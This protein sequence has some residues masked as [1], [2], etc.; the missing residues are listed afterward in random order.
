MARISEIHYSNDHASNTGVGEFFEVALSPGEDPADFVVS[1]YNQNGN[2]FV[3]LPLT[4]PGITSTVNP[5]TGETIYVINGATYGFV[6]TD[7]NGGNSNNEAV[8]LTDVSGTSNVVIDF[9]DVGGG[10]TAITANNGAA[11]GVT[12]TN[13]AGDFG[14][15]IQFNQPN[16]DT[17]IFAETSPGIACFVAGTPI[18]TSKGAI[19]IEDLSVG[20]LVLTM[21]NGFKPIRWI[22]SQTVSGMGRFAPYKITAGQFRACADTYLSPAHRV[23]LKNWRAELFFGASEVLVPVNSL[24]NHM[25]ITRA[26]RAEVIYVHMMFD[27]HE[28]VF[29]NGVASESFLPGDSGLDAMG[30]ETQEEIFA[31]FPELADDLGLYGAPARPILRGYE[32]RILG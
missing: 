23:L 10:T 8:A 6:L 22:K 21:D 13:L 12:S 9:Y 18:T 27:Q 26:P 15:S 16:P 30:A 20:D 28:I 1:T 24:A 7:P 5:G 2:V 3:E 29:S 25:G 19:P 32:A 31:L 11:A 4:D 17:P 14:F